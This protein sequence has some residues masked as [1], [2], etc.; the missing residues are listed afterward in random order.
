MSINRI[1]R[2]ENEKEL[3]IYRYPLLNNTIEMGASLKVGQDEAAVLVKDGIVYDVF[4]RGEHI[5]TSVS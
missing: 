4:P 2:P 1:E 3:F 5:L